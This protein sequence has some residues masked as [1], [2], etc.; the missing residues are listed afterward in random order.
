MTGTDGGPLLAA[1]GVVAGYGRASVLH[2]VSFSAGAGEAV[3]VLGS[4]GAGKSTLFKVLAGLHAPRAGEV[5]LHGARATGRGHWAL[6][7]AG[8]VYVAE[9]GR[10]FGAMTVVENLELAALARGRLPAAWGDVLDRCFDLF[11]VLRDKRALHA[12]GLSGGQRQMLAVARGIAARPS[13]LLL[14]EPA[15]GLSGGVV[16][17]LAAAV[18]HLSS[19]GVA[20]VVADQNP[21][22]LELSTTGCHVLNHGR[23]TWS[24][25]AAALGASQEAR[26]AAIGAGLDAGTP[27]PVVP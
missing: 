1:D 24:G 14:D 13:V 20:V 21:E 25:T 18:R 3:G 26:D 5:R 12:G 8:L 6:A 19:E 11:P 27:D 17:E 16:R 2:G 23:V 9:G 10:V 4:N 15:V 22:F 7:R